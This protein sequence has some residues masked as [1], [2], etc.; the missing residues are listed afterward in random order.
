MAWEAFICPI[1]RTNFLM[2]HQRKNK[3]AQEGLRL[4]LPPETHFNSE[5]L[6]LSA[7]HECASFSVKPLNSCIFLLSCNCALLAF[8]NQLLFKIWCSWKGGR[9]ENCREEGDFLQMV[10]KGQAIEIPKGLEQWSVA[11][12]HPF[13]WR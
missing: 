1:Y 2:W 5:V 10:R 9:R 3:G 11:L 4:I 13:S 7:N 6:C 8:H 12:E